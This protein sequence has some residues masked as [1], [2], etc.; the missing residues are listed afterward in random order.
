MPAL[1]TVESHGFVEHGE[2]SGV[3]A[4]VF[5]IGHGLLQVGVRVLA[6]PMS[7]VDG[8]ESGEECVRIEPAGMIAGIVGIAGV[9]RIFGCRSSG[10]AIAEQGHRI[11]G[12]HQR[13]H[14]R[15]FGTSAVVGI[16]G[17]GSGVTSWG[18]I[19]AVRHGPASPIPD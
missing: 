9:I 17:H 15:V 12:R 7:R 2:Q 5:G 13:I 6:G 1:G 19:V 11:V 10:L 8:I 3:I 14:E 18:R 4:G 16:A